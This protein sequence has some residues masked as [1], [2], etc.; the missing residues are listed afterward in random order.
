MYHVHC[1]VR[2]NIYK[3]IYTNIYIQIYTY[4]YTKKYIYIYIHIYIYK[5]IQMHSDCILMT[6]ISYIATDPPRNLEPDM[7]PG[8][9]SWNP[10]T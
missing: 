2:S 4:I 10:D 3:Y 7:E 1:W 6:F 5:Y 9:R 8:R